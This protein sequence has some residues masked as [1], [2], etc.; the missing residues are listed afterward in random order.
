RIWAN[1]AAAVVVRDDVPV[2]TDDLL[3]EIAAS[4]RL[5]VRA[6][7]ALTREPILAK[8]W[9]LWRKSSGDA[10][11][12]GTVRRPS[13]SEAWYDAEYPEGP[14]EL[15]FRPEG[16]APY[17]HLIAT[18]RIVAGEDRRLEIAMERGVHAQFRLE[19]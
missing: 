15:M 10:N 14:L 8:D 12:M 18:T 17:Q 3:L 13:G 9:E 5:A 4:G 1:L 6:V 19:P 2:G 7:D 16:T 11:F